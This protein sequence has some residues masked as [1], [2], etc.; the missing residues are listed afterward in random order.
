MKFG[1]TMKQRNCLIAILI[2]VALSARADEP[3]PDF[4][5]QI[6]PIFQKYCT[7]CH[8]AKDR[9]G[10]L[11]LESF[12]ELQKGS[13]SG[14]VLLAGQADSSRLIRVLTGAAEPAMPPEG[15]KAPTATGDR[16]C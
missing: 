15:E 11:N 10:K 14:V 16:S 8:N 1:S 4:V 3:K 5:K 7:G 6:A 9:E 13:E 2:L 12:A